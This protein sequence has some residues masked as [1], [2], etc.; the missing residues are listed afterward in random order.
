MSTCRLLSLSLALLTALGCASSRQTPVD[1]GRRPQPLFDAMPFDDWR[2]V[3]APARF[4]LAADDAGAMV[5]TGRGPI[6]SNGFLTSPRPLG[7]FRLE[8]DVRLGSADNPLGDKMNSGIQ[9]RSAEKGGAV[10]GLQVEVDPSKRSWSGGI[11]DERGRLWLAPLDGTDAAGEAARAAFRRGEWNRYEIE[12]I[13]PRIR[14]RVNG[15]ACAEWYDAVVS[16]L[17]AFQVHGGPPCEVAF[18]DARIEE[19]GS[20]A[21]RALEVGAGASSGERCAWSAPLAS[22]ARGVRVEVVGAGRLALSAADGSPIVDV[23]FTA[24]DG[25]AARR[26]E[27]VWVDG[28]GA[29]L[30]DGRRAASFAADAVPAQARVLGESCSASRPEWLARD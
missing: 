18:R 7:D 27:A 23:S 19:F 17:L 25:G 21:W 20:H 13:G 5:L 29:V 9:I 10:G 6:P 3:G 1:A 28:A 12:C 8:V 16:G 11:Y 22:V 2:V 4:S 26:I 30:V 14:T 15:V 24:A